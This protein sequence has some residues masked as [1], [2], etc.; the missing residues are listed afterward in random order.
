MR[1]QA[2]TTL[3]AMEALVRVQARVRG[4]CVRMSKEGQAVQNKILRRRQLNTRPSKS[5][6]RQT[7]GRWDASRGTLQ[8]K[9]AK[10]SSREEGARKRERAMSYAFSQQVLAGYHL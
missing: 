8:D 4:R 7:D 6:L 5:A 9:S 2:A 3:R 1:R 10:T